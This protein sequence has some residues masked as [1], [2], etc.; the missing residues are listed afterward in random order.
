MRLICQ[1]VSICFCV[2]IGAVG[3]SAQNVPDAQSLLGYQL[4]ERY[5]PHHRVVSTVRAVAE[6]SD[7]VVV[8][9]YGRTVEDRELLLCFVTSAANHKRLDALRDQAGKLADPR[10]L[11]PGERG[12]VIA[13]DL[14]VFVWLAY[15]VHGNETSCTEAGLATLFELARASDGDTRKLLEQAV[16][17]IDPC[18]NPDGRDRY[19]NWF[20]SVVGRKG[21][22]HTR[23]LEHRE[24]WPGGRYNHYL[25]DLNRDWAN[26]SQRETRLRIEQFIKWSPHVYVDFHEMGMESSYFFFPADKP[27][28]ANFPRGILKWGEIFGKGNAAAFDREGWAYYT[29]ESF[30][31]FYPGYGD[32]WPSLQGAIG[33]TYEQAGGSRSGITARR[34]DRS[35]ITLTDR[36]DHHRVASM[37]TIRTAVKNRTALL[38]DYLDFRQTA[39]EEGRGGAIREY[40]LDP[41]HDA[42]R[43]GRLV[44]TLIAQGVE[45]RRATKAFTAHD[46]TGFDGVRRDEVKFKKGM[47][48]VSLAQ[49]TKRL[50]KT[51]LEP[52]AEIRELYFYDVAAWSMPYAFGVK[53]WWSGSSLDVEAEKI[54]KAFVPTGK[55]AEGEAIYGYLLRW[56]TL[57]GIRTALKL[58]S[59]GIKVHCAHKPFTLDGKSFERGTLI[60]PRG[61]NPKDLETQLAA[62]A[63][64]T[65][66]TFLPARSGMTEKG[67]DLGSNYV[68]PLKA[69]RV[70]LVGGRGISATSYGATRFLLEELFEIPYSSFSLESLDGLDLRGYTTV[71]FPTGRVQ[72]EDGARDTLRRFVREGGVIIASGGS[73]RGFLKSNGGLTPIKMQNNTKDSKE[74]PYR[75]IEERESDRRSRSTPGSI[76]R[77]TLDPAHPLSFGH[78]QDVAVFKRGTSSFDPSAGGTVVGRFADAPPLSGYITEET[79]KKMRGGAYAISHGIGRGRIVLFAEDPNFRSAWHG[80]SRLFLNAVL[81]LPTQ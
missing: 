67:I 59:G 19:V 71:V 29:G 66:V 12:S 70:A 47:Y 54:Q 55:V 69:P 76:F 53:A 49:P 79:E 11:S 31:L 34:R 20:N 5:T 23:S 42:E 22:P 27:V 14:P 25:F 21:D 38:E 52:A 81:L 80:L 10:R 44:E 40:I 37:A 4:G 61:G 13:K 30:D 41:G 39:I 9:S 60:I 56:N 65:H 24:P 58:L 48:L 68:R 26:M 74:E 18:V 3:A 7:R 32:S 62:I 72:L 73:T 50:I 15:N 28:H 1:V 17:I 63:A 8:E 33:M 6:A 51:L 36:V 45:V 64:S 43:A 35:L 75:T 57:A 77:V 46:I 2:V 78:G 16:I